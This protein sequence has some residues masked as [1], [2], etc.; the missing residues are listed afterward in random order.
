MTV[1]MSQ[2]CC[3]EEWRW[4]VNEKL[5]GN[6]LWLKPSVRTPTSAQLDLENQ[7]NTASER[8]LAELGQFIS[9]A[10]RVI[11]SVHRIQSDDWIRIHKEKPKLIKPYFCLLHFCMIVE[12]RQYTWDIDSDCT[13]FYWIIYYFRFRFT[14]RS[15]QGYQ[16]TDA[17]RLLKA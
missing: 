10:C 3:S 14:A 7:L 2:L 12:C 6:S 17:C 15:F 16:L 8:L 13:R 9:F 4:L 5:Q 1:A 11:R